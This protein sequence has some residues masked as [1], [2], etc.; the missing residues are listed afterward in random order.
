MD[1][2]FFRQPIRRMMLEGKRIVVTGVMT[3]QSIAYS[4]AEA[5]QRLGAEVVLTSFGRARRMTERAARSLPDP[6]D[7]LE[8][9]VERP[10]HFEALRESLRTRW[11]SVDGVVHAIAHGNEQAL[12]SFLGVPQADVERTLRISAYSLS[13]LSSALQPLFDPKRGAGIVSLTL[14]ASVAYP[15]YNWM[16]VSKAALESI[17]RY[18]ASELGPRGVRVN[19]VSPGPIKSPASG[20][21][22]DFGHATEVWSARAPLGWDPDD[23]KP[24]AETVCFLLSNHARGIT[25]EILHVDGGFHA[26]SEIRLSLDDDSGAAV[27]GRDP[28]KVPGNRT[29]GKGGS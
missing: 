26:V 8:L 28:S 6:P 3:K 7:V 1:G 23:A 2:A 5:A 29:E 25:G 16:G 9:D 13:A 17:S 12:D 24:V 10:E 19:V 11:P 21:W 18:L 27:G 4:I 14:D 15:H 22:S 20:Y